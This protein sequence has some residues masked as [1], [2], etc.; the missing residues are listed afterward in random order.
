MME[1]KGQSICT[2]TSTC[3]CT[4]Y[5]CLYHIVDNFWPST[6]GKKRLRIK[7]HPDTRLRQSCEAYTHAHT[8]LA[9]HIPQFSEPCVRVGE[10]TQ[11]SMATEATYLAWSQ[12]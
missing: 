9:G 8:A 1:K 6:F 5:T 4:L 7:F 2:C 10:T 3:M 12:S 11:L